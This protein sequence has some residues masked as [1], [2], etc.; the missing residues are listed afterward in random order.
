VDRLT[1]QTAIDMPQPGDVLVVDKASCREWAQK[2]KADPSGFTGGGTFT[3]CVVISESSGEM[4]LDKVL[5]TK[6]DPSDGFMECV[7]RLAKHLHLDPAQIR[8]KRGYI[9]MRGVRCLR[10]CYVAE[11]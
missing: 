7:E 8:S 9:N 11:V 1:N 6:S 3:D 10:M 5:T 4:W 2:I